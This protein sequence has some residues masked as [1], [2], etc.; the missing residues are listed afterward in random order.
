MDGRTTLEICLI[1]I[2]I[3]ILIKDVKCMMRVLNL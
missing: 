2:K 3:T 1:K